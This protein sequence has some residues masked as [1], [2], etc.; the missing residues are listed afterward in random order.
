MQERRPP[1]R[2]QLRLVWEFWP[3]P[4]YNLGSMI[5]F[6]QSGIATL[7]PDRP[8]TKLASTPGSAHRSPNT[9]GHRQKN[10]QKRDWAVVQSFCKAV[11]GNVRDA[12]DLEFYAALDH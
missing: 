5:C 2:R 4:L 8:T 7:R 1:I 3:P 12:L 11:G 9:R 6:G 10:L